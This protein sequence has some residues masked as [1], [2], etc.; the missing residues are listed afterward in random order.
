MLGFKQVYISLQGEG[1]I[2]NRA[3]ALSELKEKNWFVFGLGYT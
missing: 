2:V 3:Q 1:E